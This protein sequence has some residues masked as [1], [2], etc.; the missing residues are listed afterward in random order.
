M[1]RDIEQ[2]IQS[3]KNLCVKLEETIKDIKQN[4]Y[5]RKD[6]YELVMH[7][8]DVGGRLKFFWDHDPSFPGFI[9]NL[10]E[11]AYAEAASIDGEGPGP[12]PDKEYLVALLEKCLKELDRMNS[13]LFHKG[14]DWWKREEDTQQNTQA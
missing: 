13:A 10:S 6:N 12:Q 8:R 11:R 5:P 4:D 1:N 2:V 7:L 14:R 3:I 9:L